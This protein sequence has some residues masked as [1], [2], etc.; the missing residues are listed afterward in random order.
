MVGARGF[1]LFGLLLS[2]A[3]VAAAAQPLKVLVTNDDGVAAPGID[4]LVDTLAANP[5]LALTVVAPANNSSGTGESVTHAPVDV[6]AGATASGFPATVVDGFPADAVLFGILQR[7]Q[8]DPPDL[9]VSGVN[10][11][12]NLSAEL[13]GLSGTVGAATWAAREGIPAFAVSAG[14]AA[15]PD[16]AQAA[17]LTADLVEAFRIK[18]GF[19]K[20]MH[21]K[22]APFRGLVLNVN[23][24]TCGNVGMRG[25]RVVPVGRLAVFTGY[26]LK[27]DVGGLQSWQLTVASGGNFLFS[28]CTSTKVKVVSDVDGFSNGFATVTPLDPERNSTGRKLKDFEFVADLF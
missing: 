22:E 25:V 1:V 26:T 15:S 19:R 28:D 3:G 8:D 11:G 10:F 23:V 16:Y 7:M 5:N 14:L 4:V 21:E 24:P 12:Q 6:S 18:G 17:Q 13:I 27:S 9:V 2:I 20:K